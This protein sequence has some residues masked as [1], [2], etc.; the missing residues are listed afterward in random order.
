MTPKQAWEAQKDDIFNVVADLDRPS[1]HI[2]YAYLAGVETHVSLDHCALQQ[3][4]ATSQAALAA[5]LQRA[6][7]FREYAGEAAGLHQHIA[8]YLTVLEPT[9][10]PAEHESRLSTQQQISTHQDRATE[11]RAA[12]AAAPPAPAGDKGDL[13]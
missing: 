13:G 12:L 1:E 7:A 9:W 11:I 2:E 3:Q 4:L 5:A 10:L 6:E 8:D